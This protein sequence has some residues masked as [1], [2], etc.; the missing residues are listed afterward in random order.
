M[1]SCRGAPRYI[2]SASGVLQARF[3]EGLEKVEFGAALIAIFRGSALIRP[4]RFS[5]VISVAS[6]DRNKWPI[7]AFAHFRIV[8]ITNT[9]ALIFFGRPSLFLYPHMF[10][11][12][13]FCQNNEMSNIFNFIYLSLKRKMPK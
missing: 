7:L 12:F 13:L 11:M 6:C 2:K 4:E 3:L 10:A 8:Y 5:C 1:C 9:R